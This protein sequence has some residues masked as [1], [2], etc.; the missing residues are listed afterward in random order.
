MLKSTDPVHIYPGRS[1]VLCYECSTHDTDTCADPFN[2]S[3]AV[4]PEVMVEECKGA[5]VKWV[6]RPKQGNIYIR[7]ILNMRL[8]KFVL[9]PLMKNEK[10]SAKGQ[11]M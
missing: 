5:C 9:D 6:T 2:E 10:N 1:E 8:F 11:T 4:E 7:H 3:E